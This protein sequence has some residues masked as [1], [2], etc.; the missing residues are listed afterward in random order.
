LIQAF[1]DLHNAEL[2]DDYIRQAAGQF[3]TQFAVTN[4]PAPLATAMIA[5]G[6][7][8][9]SRA[10]LSRFGQRVIARENRL[11]TICGGVVLLT[12]IGALAFMPGSSKQAKQPPADLPGQHNVV[13]DKPTIPEEKKDPVVSTEHPDNGIPVVVTPVHPPDKPVH[14]KDLVRDKKT[15]GDDDN[16]GTK[17]VKTEKPV[18]DHSGDEK[19]DDSKEKKKDPLG[20][21]FKT[22]KKKEPGGKDEPG[23]KKLKG[24]FK[25]NKN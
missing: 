10:T 25:K 9:K 3:K 16:S 17:D 13:V 5:T 18:E 14:K 2:T 22:H 12:A 23:W 8:A 21:L 6:A 15:G 24:L 19:K 4:R 20:D 11:I 7:V 1:P